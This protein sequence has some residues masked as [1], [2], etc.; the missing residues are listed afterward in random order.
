MTMKLRVQYVHLQVDSF[1]A[2]I[3]L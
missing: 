1:R 3:Q 2:I